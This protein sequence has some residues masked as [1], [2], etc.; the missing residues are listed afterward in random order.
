MIPPPAV[1]VARGTRAPDGMP[2]DAD[3]MIDSHRTDR[4]DHPLEWRTRAADR[5]VAEDSL[6]REEK[7][8]E[9]HL[10]EIEP[11]RETSRHAC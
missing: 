10:S 7:A 3:G 2:G 9:D 4:D 1:R 11:T 6:R 5:P 8:A